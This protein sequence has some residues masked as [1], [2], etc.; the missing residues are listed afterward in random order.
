[1]AVWSKDP[2]EQATLEELEAAGSA[3]PQG[4]DLALI[5]VNNLNANKLDYY[6]ERQVEVSVSVGSQTAEVTQRVRLSN[7]APDGLVTHVAGFDEPGT[8][9]ER[10]EF[11][12]AQAATVRSLHRDGAV[13][14]GESRRGIERTRVHTYVELA[15]GQS[16]ELV[17]RYSVPVTDGRYRLRLLPQP[18]ARHARLQ[19]RIDP[20]DG[21]ALYTEGAGDPGP[22]RQDGAW[23]QTEVLSVVAR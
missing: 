2:T 8:V 21:L 13:A 7:G 18:L 20:G 17:L 15:R 12:I 22:V 4:D 1:V 19:V 16:T 3:D 9:V 10:V 5:A 11:S 6:V 23:T 14:N